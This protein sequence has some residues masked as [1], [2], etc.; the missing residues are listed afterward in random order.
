MLLLDFDAKVKHLKHICKHFQ[1]YFTLFALFFIIFVFSTLYVHFICFIMEKKDIIRIANEL[2][3][4]AGISGKKFS[5]KIGKENPQWLYDILSERKPNGFSRKIVQLITD[6]YP[7]IN[8]EYLSS[9][10]GSLLKASASGIS[11]CGDQTGNINSPGA[12]S[13]DSITKLVEVVH[14]QSKQISSLIQII[15]NLSGKPEE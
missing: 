5:E 7:E 14:E 9:G 1:D 15:S 8:G 2:L 13:G 3:A 11:V 6:E 4:Y 12:N 10:T